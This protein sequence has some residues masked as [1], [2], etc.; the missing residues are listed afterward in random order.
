MPRLSDWPSCLGT[1][2]GMSQRAACTALLPGQL[3]L[4][5][6]SGEPLGLHQHAAVPPHSSAVHMPAG[7]ATAANCVLRS[8]IR[9][10]LAC[11][12]LAGTYPASLKP[13]A[14]ATEAAGA[15]VPRRT[16]PCLLVSCLGDP[17][18]FY[19][20]PKGKEHLQLC[21]LQQRC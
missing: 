6:P 19:G 11:P 16:F 10:L 14:A 3:L 20:A 7:A 9:F 17:N 4:Q 1:G 2:A 18:R 13:A 5:Q 15:L 21:M 12:T 8:I